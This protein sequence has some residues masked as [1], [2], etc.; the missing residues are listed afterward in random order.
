MDSVCSSMQ[1]KLHA[2]NCLASIPLHRRAGKAGEAHENRQMAS[3]HS[4]DKRIYYRLK[5]GQE[6]RDDSISYQ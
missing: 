1:I 3:I 5:D 6:V 4:K 2:T